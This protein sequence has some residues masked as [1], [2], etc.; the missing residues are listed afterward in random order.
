MKHFNERVA[1]G[2]EPKPFSS[3]YC[4]EHTVVDQE[5]AHYLDLVKGLFPVFLERPSVFYES[6]IS[7]HLEQFKKDSAKINLRYIL[8]RDRTM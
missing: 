4:F 8:S 5:L 1:F 2:S 6:A 7:V 3:R